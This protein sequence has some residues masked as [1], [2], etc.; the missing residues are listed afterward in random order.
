M[1]RGGKADRKV[2][3]CYR[4]RLS[5]NCLWRNIMETYIVDWKISVFLSFPIDGLSSFVSFL[6]IANSK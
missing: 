2:G 6:R 1:C 4:S 5:P 3:D